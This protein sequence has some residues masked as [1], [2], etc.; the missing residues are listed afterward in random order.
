MQIG[1]NANKRNHDSGFTRW[2][3]H[4]VIKIK[5]YFFKVCL[6]YR[7]E[8]KP[9]LREK[10]TKVLTIYRKGGVLSITVISVGNGISDLSSNPE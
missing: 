3:G 8:S 4:S 7:E 10:K 9:F 1:L 6:K 2:G 5:R